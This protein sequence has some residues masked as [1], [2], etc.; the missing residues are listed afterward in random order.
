MINICCVFYG[1][2]YTSDYVQKLYN[3]VQRHLTIPYNFYCFTDHSNLDDTI[4]GNI[5]FKELPIHGHEGWWNKLQLFNKD[6]NLT[7][8]NLYF[9]LDI[10]I[11]KNIDSFATHGDKNSFCILREFNQSKHIFNSSIMKWNNNTTSFI[12]DDYN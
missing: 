10:V 2:K 11:L 1:N 3:M 6:I 5:I 4:S 7:G 12:W 9:D 8:V